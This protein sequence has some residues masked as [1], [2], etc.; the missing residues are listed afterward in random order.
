MRYRFTNKITVFGYSSFYL[1]PHNIQ[2]K[3]D[4]PELFVSLFV[5]FNQFISVQL[6]HSFVT[7]FGSFVTDYIPFWISSTSWLIL[8]I[9]QREGTYMKHCYSSKSETL[10]KN[11]VRRVF[12]LFIPNNLFSFLLPTPFPPT[13]VSNQSL[14]SQLSFQYFFYKNVSI[15]TYFLISLYTIPSHMESSMPY[16]LFCIFPFHLVISMSWK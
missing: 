3:Y 6:C 13:S 14:V 16:I 7:Q 1:Q 8:I 11:I 4:F 15:H 12:S 9:C 10:L 5:F 2:S